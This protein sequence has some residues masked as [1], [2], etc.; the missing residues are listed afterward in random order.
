MYFIKMKNLVQTI[1]SE[2]EVK[3]F[4]LMNGGFRQ[5][6]EIVAIDNSELL[7]AAAAA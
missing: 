7:E 5:L 1:A 4:I 3:P 2:S 6:A